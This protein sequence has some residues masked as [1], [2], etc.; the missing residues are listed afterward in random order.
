MKLR[1]RFKLVTITGF[2]IPAGALLLC[3]RLLPR[4]LSEPFGSV[5]RCVAGGQP[6]LSLHPA[7]RE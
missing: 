5:F 4:T 3:A 6:C 7:R 2:Y 1:R